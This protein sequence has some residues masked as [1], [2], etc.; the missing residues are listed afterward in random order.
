MAR[1][2][3]TVNLTA[4]RLVTA[5]AQRRRELL[6]AQVVDAQSARGVQMPGPDRVALSGPQGELD[7]LLRRH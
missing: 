2:D 3:T 4:I 6:Q 1:Y 5:R 7:Q